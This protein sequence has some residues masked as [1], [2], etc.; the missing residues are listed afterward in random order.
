LSPSCEQ[1]VRRIRN[2]VARSERGSADGR[3]LLFR[4]TGV[5][6]LGMGSLEADA[7]AEW[8]ET[9]EVA[10]ALRRGW[11]RDIALLHGELCH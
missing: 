7:D 9:L 3:R 10:R 6:V 5:S 1:R 4:Y 11:N 2:K 8:E